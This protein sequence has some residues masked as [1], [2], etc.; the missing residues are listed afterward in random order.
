[1]I[2][3]YFTWLIGLIMY[4]QHQIK[5]CCFYVVMH[6]SIVPR[7]SVSLTAI[8]SGRI[9]VIFIVFKLQSHTKTEWI[10]NG[11]MIEFISDLLVLTAQDIVQKWRYFVSNSKSLL[12]CQIVLRRVDEVPRNTRYAIHQ[13]ENLS[14]VQQIDLK[15]NDTYWY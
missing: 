6:N 13:R 4:T 8:L 1:M 12:K 14:P 3:I 2:C 10:T 9:L 11:Y 5:S 7:W 15:E